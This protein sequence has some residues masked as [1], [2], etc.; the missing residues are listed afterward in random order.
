MLSVLPPPSG[1]PLTWAAQ[2]RFEPWTVTALLAFGSVYAA[3]MLRLGRKGV[4]WKR[5]TGAAFFAGLGC[6]AV[7]LCSPVDA[8]ADVSFRVHMA[9]HLALT[10]L[11]P[12]LLALGQPLT[13]ALRA[14]SPA[15]GRRLARF[16]A[17]RPASFLSRP[18]VGW[19]LFV[20]VAY[21]VH[22]SPLFDA[23]LRSQPLHAFEHALWLAAALVFWWPI[24][25]SDAS[26]HPMRYP[27]RVL[28]LF[29]TMPA[30]AFL[31]LVLYTAS[32]PMYAAYAALPS[33]WG[34]AALAD[35]RNAAVLM[36]IAGNLALSTAM[37]L[38]AAAWKRDDDARQRRLEA[39]AD[40]VS[41]GAAPPI[42]RLSRRA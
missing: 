6:I 37:L 13:L 29:L 39:R 22:L 25:G 41:E 9:Q 23:A 33:P 17:G 24:V 7:A 10:L 3:G 2:W 16:L 36:W 30:M 1:G 35:Q 34:P 19:S 21:A 28:S 14:T 20:G 4:R 18:V 12:P 40:A 11:A 32:A 15:F 26:A 42:D 5:A 38:V 27:T 31:A 8:Y